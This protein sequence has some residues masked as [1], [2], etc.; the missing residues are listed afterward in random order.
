[1]NKILFFILL[2]TF[3]TVF[4]QK[5]R[6]DSFF[7][8][9]DTL[10]DNELAFK[11]LDEFKIA[12]KLNDTELLAYYKQRIKTS[13]KLQK[14]DVALQST[15]DGLI[16][17]RKLKNDSLISFFTDRLGAVY[18]HIGQKDKAE[19]EFE[20]SIK[21]AEKCHYYELLAKSLSNLGAIK[22]EKQEYLNAEKY[23]KKS[24]F[25]F[26][27]IKFSPKEYIIPNRLLAT[28][29]E[30]TKR[31]ELAKQKYI[32]V[33]KLSEDAKDTTMMCFSYVY[34]ARLLEKTGNIKLA[35]LNFEKAL[36]LA[37]LSKNKN[38]IEV[39]Y[40]NL[41]NCYQI[42]KRFNKSTLMYREA[43]NLNKKLFQ[44]NLSESVAETEV[45]YKTLEIKQ[46]KELA[47][48]KILAEKRKNQLYVFVFIGILFFSII[49]FLLI[50]FKQIS[51]RKKI[52]LA[53]QKQ[54]LEAILDAQEE[55]KVRIARD[56]HD[57]ICQKF[58]ATKLRFNSLNLLDAIPEIQ[59]NYK[60]CISLL[61]EATNELRTIAHE[62][63][64][65]ALSELRLV[66]A[67]KQ[68]ANQCFHNQI[69]YTFEVFGKHFNFSQNEEINIYRIVQELFSN[70]IKHARA[71]EVSIQIVFS[72]KQFSLFVE[73][74]GIGFF[75]K[76]KT[77]M[78][79]SNIKLRSEIIN[80]KFNIE[81]GAS[82]GTFVSIIKSEQ[83]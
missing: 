7:K 44:E 11:K 66:E 49:I 54:H 3:S 34:Y 45:K 74:N 24:I 82:G 51:K 22:I 14:Y 81:P 69:E 19:I 42:N 23:L 75:S 32:D 10:A 56:L 6:Y 41:A 37:L 55:E 79:L 71:S 21:L 48:A 43:Y 16:L 83:N 78:G 39:C 4:S 63:M 61:D 59:I 33:I 15:N 65:P 36:E 18:Y 50:Y 80:A 40:L 28:L 17:A 26:N 57:G 72:K 9:F 68:L 20:K 52:E 2:L 47:E 38:T 70:V 5:N 30:E 25:Y 73:D 76:D 77:G 58:A 46:Q 53:L 62:I 35:I 67:I 1:M 29:Y 13:I 31:Y 12:K 27:K 8:G 60:N 64:P